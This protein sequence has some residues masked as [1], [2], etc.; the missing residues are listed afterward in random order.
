MFWRILLFTLLAYFLYKLIVGLIIPVFKTT[1]KMRKDFNEI[2]GR[3]NSFMNEQQQQ[4]NSS[5]K[6][7]EPPVTQNKSKDYID[8]EEIK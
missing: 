7:K 3:M 1:R 2:K 4:N 8:F 6:P 5:F